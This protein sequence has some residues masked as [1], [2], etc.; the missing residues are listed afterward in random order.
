MV[1]RSV[2]KNNKGGGLILVIG[3][4]AL[5]SLVGAMLLA[6]TANNRKMKDL[7]RQMQQSFYGAESGS[8]EMVTQ[9]EVEAEEALKRAFAD[10]MAQYSLIPEANRLAHYAEFFEKEFRQEVTR[11]D[12]AE[13]IMRKA[14]GLEAGDPLAVEVSFG[15]VDAGSFDPVA[16][17]CELCIRNARFAYTAAG[18]SQTTITTDIR[19][20]A[21]IPDVN[22]SMSEAVVCDFSDFAVISGED[23]VTSLNTSQGIMIDGNFYTENSLV[24][25]SSD[26]TMKI[27][28]AKKLLVGN[29]LQVLNKAKL[30]INGGTLADGEGVWTT[31]ISVSDGG[32]LTADSNFYVSDDLTISGT[33]AK[34]VI[35][36][37]EYIGY[38][39]GN[40]TLTDPSAG[41]SAIT[42]N[43]AKDITLDFG[44]TTDLILTG[45][46]YIHDAL[47][48]RA[49]LTGLT[50]DAAKEANKLGV[51]QGESMAYKDMQSMYLV[52]GECLV[53]GHNPMTK[54]EYSSAAGMGEIMISKRFRYKERAEYEPEDVG[55]FDLTE[56]LAAQPYVVRHVKLDGGTTEFVYLYL[57]FKNTTEAQRFFAAYMNISELAEPLKKHLSNLGNSFIELAQNNYTLANSF[58]YDSAVGTGSYE[59]AEATNQFSVLGSNSL[60]AQRRSTGLFTYFRKDASAPTGAGFDI[61][62]NHI[63]KMN[64]FASVPENTWI[65]QQ[66]VVNGATYDF[67]VHNGD[68]EIT[69]GLDSTLK[70]G[71]I[72][73]NGRL[74][75][76]QTTAEFHG[77][78]LATGGID[79]NS[80][81]E[82]YSDRAAVDA[83]LTVPEVQK[84]FRAAGGAS[85][86]DS[87]LSSEAVTISF[88]N[89]QKN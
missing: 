50:D 24:H 73:V 35:S 89:W 1:R 11:S 20:N 77:L 27:N 75:L 87:Y 83:L 64:Q 6:V 12:A 32:V 62:S 7:E 72:L 56:Y 71:I 28:N 54:E 25:S 61:V 81:T 22:G 43:T 26:M 74:T 65:K 49:G 86:A 39:G 68:A 47:W 29:E 15:S 23:V 9:L 76:K 8:G 58:A 16:E 34:A 40:G 5:L 52:P 41:S 3:C 10:L 66:Y 78:V 36:G 37:D 45:S 4:V 67:W 82:I 18:G 31:G 46:S 2:L 59:V 79:F 60:L 30:N 17:T 13:A 85:P 57:N 88:E 80:D 69:T 51:L 44:G 42:I 84:Y 48:G 14:L 19:I 55:T 70:G 21:K 53:T 38:S 33:G 63:L